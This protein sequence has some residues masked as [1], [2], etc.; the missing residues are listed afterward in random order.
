MHAAPTI[1][2][3][4]SVAVPVSV[5]NSED[6]VMTLTAAF[7]AVY[8]EQISYRY[9][10]QAVQSR[11]RCLHYWIPAPFPVLRRLLVAPAV[12]LQ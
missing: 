1:L 6:A 5:T 2:L 4:V 11:C 3:Q 8:T 7:T 10:A 12:R 9:L